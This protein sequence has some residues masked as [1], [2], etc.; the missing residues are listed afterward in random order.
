MKSRLDSR[1]VAFRIIL[2]E[3]VQDRRG[4]IALLMRSN[5]S[6]VEDLEEVKIDSDLRGRELTVNSTSACPFLKEPGKDL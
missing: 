6:N 5:P 3:P 4:E 2:R 1:L